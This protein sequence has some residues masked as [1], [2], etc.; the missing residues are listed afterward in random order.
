MIGFPLSSG[1]SASS[2]E[3]KKAS[4]SMWRIAR[5]QLWRLKITSFMVEAFA[6]LMKTEN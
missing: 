4:P 1:W 2:Q 5:G 6:H 3:V